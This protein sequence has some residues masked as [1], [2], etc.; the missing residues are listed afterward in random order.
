[1]C[2]EP[3]WWRV[4]FCLDRSRLNRLVE[5]PPLGWVPL[6]ML[7][8]PPEIRSVSQAP[9]FG[10]EFYSV[11]SRAKIV[12]NGAIDMAGRERGNMRC[13][14]SMGCGALM[15]SDEGIYPKGMVDGATMRT[16]ENPEGV[17]DT[18]TEALENEGARRHIARAGYDMVCSQYSKRSQWESF[19]RLANAV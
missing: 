8:R 7:Q 4:V 18:V 1:M 19:L 2:G 12:I 6:G 9:V 15:V 11:L 3:P 14:E 13:F 10:R 17:A 16:Y 5:S